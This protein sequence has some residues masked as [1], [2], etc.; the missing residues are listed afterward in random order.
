MEEGFWERKGVKGAFFWIAFDIIALVLFFIAGFSWEL[1]KENWFL[2]FIAVVS[3]DRIVIPLANLPEPPRLFTFLM[4]L[5]PIGALICFYISLKEWEPEVQIKMAVV[6]L[7]TLLLWSAANIGWGIWK[8]KKD[9]DC[10]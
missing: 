2:L 8:K 3:I 9:T 6:A 5:A 4:G 1:V 10:T 7:V